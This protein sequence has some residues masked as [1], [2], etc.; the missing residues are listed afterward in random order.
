M[1][2]CAGLVRPSHRALTAQDTTSVQVLEWILHGVSIPW[3]PEGPPPPFK[4]GISCQRL[5]QDQDTFLNKEIT[6]LKKKS[7]LRPIEHSSLVSRTFLEPKP[8]GW[9][10]VIDLR[11]SNK[12]RQTRTMKME[13]LRHLRLIAK[14]GDHWVS[15]DLKDGF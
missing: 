13:T 7:V 6:R 8:R 1:G 5:P 14:P 2:W 3:L 11:T 4:D 15:F 10:L 9:R 12:H